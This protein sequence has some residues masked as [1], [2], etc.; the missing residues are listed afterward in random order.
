MTADD[1][2]DARGKLFGTGA[3]L[4]DHIRSYEHRS[5]RSYCDRTTEKR[6]KLQ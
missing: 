2:I 4:P 3:A 1:E 5:R 6:R